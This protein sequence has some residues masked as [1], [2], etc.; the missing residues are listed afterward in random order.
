VIAVLVVG[1]APTPPSAAEEERAF[2]LAPCAAQIAPCTTA[3]RVAPA[4]SFLP[5][6]G[7]G[8][9][10]ESGASIE[11]PIPASDAGRALVS[12]ALGTRVRDV[13]EGEP[14]PATELAFAIDGAVV[15]P[16]APAIRFRR[17]ETSVLAVGGGL[18]RPPP[19]ARLRIEN[20]GE[21]LAVIYAVALFR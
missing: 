16:V 1:C 17:I 20:R 19:G 14:P 3:G 21:R 11:L 7:P 4:V 12:V 5:E 13:A 2:D 6:G 9:Q 10:L 8:V 15:P 18:Y